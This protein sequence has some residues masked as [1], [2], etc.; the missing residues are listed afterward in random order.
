MSAA[1][2]VASALAV[3]DGALVFV[4]DDAGALALAGDATRVV[5][6]GGRTVLPGFIETHIH[7]LAGGLIAAGLVVAQDDTVAA[8]QEKLAKHAADHPEKKA[9]YGQ[10]YGTSMFGPEGPRKEL[11]DVVDV[12]VLLV[13]W[14]LHAAWCNTAALAVAGITAASPDLGSSGKYDRDPDGTPTGSIRSAPAYV[15]VLQAMGVIGP[16]TVAAGLGPLLGGLAAQGFTT[17]FDAGSLFAFEPALAACRAMDDKG[18]LPVRVSASYMVNNAAQMPSKPLN[19][20]EAAHRR[21][22]EG[23]ILVRTLK[24]VADGVIENRRA[25]F[26]EAYADEPGHKGALVLPPAELAAFVT[27]ASKRGFDVMLHGIG[28]AAGRAIL[29][30]FEAARKAGGKTRLVHTHAELVDPADRPHCKPLDVVVETT[31]VWMNPNPSLLPA[32]GPDRYGRRYMFRELLDSGV[33]V[34]LGSDW[35]ATSGGWLGTSAFGNMEGAVTRRIPEY[36]RAALSGNGTPEELSEILA[37]ESECWTVREAVAGY[38]NAAARQLSME[39]LVGTIEVGKRADLVLLD[40]SP[41]QVPVNEL[42]TIKILVAMMDGKVTFDA[43]GAADRSEMVFSL[44]AL[45]SC[46]IHS[47]RLCC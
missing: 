9:L 20:L 19:I 36:L 25:A 16:D 30:A 15:P 18:E 47:A 45:G 13:S 29:D 28:D 41:F 23:K 2:T 43:L 32:L 39:H 26:L 11:L 17:I 22:R 34:T 4:G 12:P 46:D 38:T 44:D 40:K 35:P 31:G 14:D 42:H 37:P 1:G 21:E 5:D 27:E 10:G 24:V 8:I 7:A 33:T 6:A 3:R